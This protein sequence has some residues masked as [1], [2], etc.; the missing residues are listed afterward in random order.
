M[1]VCYMGRVPKRCNIPAF[2]PERIGAAERFH[3]FGSFSMN[4]N[5]RGR[6]RKPSARGTGFTQAPV[7]ETHR[8]SD[9]QIKSG[10]PQKG[11]RLS[12][13]KRRP[14]R[15]ILHG[16][17]RLRWAGFSLSRVCLTV[18]CVDWQGYGGSSL[19][20]EWENWVLVWELLIWSTGDPMSCIPSPREQSLV[21]MTLWSSDC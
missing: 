12:R 11:P 15:L 8:E 4:I 5:D 14:E 13:R 20:I 16:G 7:T 19:Q 10:N 1:Q 21:V 3:S 9:L 17:W 18:A 6:S 2:L